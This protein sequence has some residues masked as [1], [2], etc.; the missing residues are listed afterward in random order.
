MRERT[1]SL[2]SGRPIRSPPPISPGPSTAP[3]PPRDPGTTHSSSARLDCGTG[4][5]WHI[6]RRHVADATGEPRHRLA[7]T[8]VDRLLSRHTGRADG[9]DPT[10]TPEV[11]GCRGRFHGIR[12]RTSPGCGR[13]RPVER[14]SP[15]PRSSGHAS[16]RC[17]TSSTIQPE[18]DALVQTPTPTTRLRPGRPG[19]RQDGKWACT[20]RH[21][22]CMPTATGSRARASSSSAPTAPS[23][24][25][26]GPCSPLSARS[27]R[28][29]LSVTSSRPGRPGHR[30]RPSATLKG[31]ARLAAV[32]R[33][34]PWRSLSTDQTLVVRAGSA[35]WRVPALR[36]PDRRGVARAGARYRDPR[37]ARA[38]ARC[39]VLL[40][41]NALAWHD[42][43]AVTRKPRQS[44]PMSE[45][46][47]R[48]R[49][50]QTAPPP[51][52]RPAVLA[53]GGRQTASSPQTA[54]DA[55][56]GQSTSNREA[57]ARWAPPT[58]TTRRTR[59]WRSRPD[60]QSRPRHPRRGPGPRR[61]NCAASAGAARRFDDRSQRDIARGRRRG[62]PL[63]WEK[64]LENISASQGSGRGARSR[65]PGATSVINAARLLPGSPQPRLRRRSGEPRP[66]RCPGC[67]S[68]RISVRWSPRRHLSAMRAPDPSAS[69]PPTRRRRACR[70]HSMP[71]AS[72]MGSSERSRRRRPPGRPRS[73]V[74]LP[75]LEFDRVIVAEPADIVAAEP[76]GA[77]AC[78]G[79]M[80]SSPAR[81]AN[82]MSSTS[83]RCHRNWWRRDHLGHT[84][85]RDGPMRALRYESLVDRSR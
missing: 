21:G 47:G 78:A 39:A 65:L 51:V 57:G 66:P 69:S 46:C 2:G 14:D 4:E 27:G 30:Q 10:P 63:S 54:S 8:G 67:R 37:D 25:T 62:R 81:S 82:S 1:E 76:D 23:W 72:P 79:S 77:P 35:N 44:P 75:R 20:G 32:L 59:R 7:R 42:Q 49:P 50:R 36:S 19:N 15:P 6:G 28:A 71:R 24:T 56:V 58:S 34:E 17:A 84:Y 22:C 60:F 13:D 26:S 5:R 9:G 41:W 48:T 80:S 38:S 64:S 43:D 45:T 53:R 61:C 33:S 3:S 18:Q 11:P 40:G 16:G 68:S 85:E 74:R 83:G 73:R 12:G 55:L 29:R 70:R 31:D 52:V